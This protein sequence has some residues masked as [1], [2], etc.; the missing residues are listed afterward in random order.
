VLFRLAKA[1]LDGG[2]DVLGEERTAENKLAQ[3]LRKQLCHLSP[4]MAVIQP[5]KVEALPR[6]ETVLDD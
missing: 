2:R 5:E 3:L 1:G 6:N 4:A